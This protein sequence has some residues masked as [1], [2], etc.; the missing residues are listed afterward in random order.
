MQFQRLRSSTVG[1][2]CGAGA[3]DAHFPRVVDQDVKMKL[4]VRL[5]KFS[6]FTSGGLY[7]PARP[8]VPTIS[9]TSQNSVARCSNMNLSYPKHNI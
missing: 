3:Y 4:E 7:L 2:A 6:R 1:Q 9:T 5:A 8:Y